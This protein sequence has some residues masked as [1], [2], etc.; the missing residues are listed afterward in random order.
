MLRSPLLGL[1]LVLGAS[2]VAAFEGE[3]VVFLAQDDANDASTSLRRF[4]SQE[5]EGGFGLDCQ[6][7]E[8]DEAGRLKGLETLADADLF[9]VFA[10]SVELAESECTAIEAYVQTGKGLL[11]LR[12]ACHGFKDWVGFN[13]GYTGANYL[14]SWK[15][16]GAPSLTVLP[17]GETHP[18][19][20]GLDL[21]RLEAHGPLYRVLPLSET[22]TA[23]I[24]GRADG[25]REAEPVA[26]TSGF[27]GAPIFVT[28]L[29]NAADF[30]QAIFTDI[31]TR[32]TFWCMRR[33]LP[34]RRAASPVPVLGEDDS[35]LLFDGESLDGWV[36]RGGRYDGDARWSV[37]DGAMVGREGPGRA[38]GLIYTERPYRNFIIS[39]ETR[40]DY[41]FDSG[42]FLRMV[43][44][45][46][47]KGAQVT[48]DYRPGG[49]VGAIYA[50]GFLERNEAGM[51][52][53]A[54]DEWNEVVV[55]CVGQDMHITAWLNGE[56]LTDYEMPK[57][58]EG[59]APTGLIGLQVHGGSDAPEGQRAMFR[60]VRLR[61]L[62]DFDSE[63]YRVDD[64]GILSLKDAGQEAGWETLFNG[65]D[66]EGWDPRPSAKSYSVEQGELIFPV[67]GGGGEI[68]T[69]R[70]FRDFELRLDFKI[71]RMA[72]SGLFL[73][74]DPEAT[75][76]SFSGCEVQILDDFNWEEVTGTTLAPYQVS[77]GLYGS[78]APGVKDA[79]RPLGEWNTYDVRYVGTRLRVALNGHE[80][81][82]VDTLEVPGKPPFAERVPRGF[83]GLQ[84]H[85]PPEAKGDH[86]AWFRNIFVRELDGANR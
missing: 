54:K 32:A 11:C 9:I 36:T 52:R 31:L 59:Y 81:Y 5:L 37:E 65:R 85:A 29:G 56:L 10:D 27:W 70:L 66:L 33:P 7:L 22:A 14:G 58:T 68:R 64:R 18:I 48:L 57:G 42:V 39:F 12:S 61:E 55:R 1:A 6:F 71:A 30:E 35:T 77:G 23:L 73:R 83:I 19:L 38:G 24:E 43:P 17:A 51:A 53:F 76:S 2:P 28:T 13:N 20:A 46:G 26:W 34:K 67:A 45:G 75:N 21:S 49:Q 80:L 69:R 41:P 4:A 3:R 84:R 62:P 16:A 15:D 25:I 8:R 82:D 74:S 78:V 79:L 40:I 72:N 44:P 60:D 63:L 47:G 50:D 86:F